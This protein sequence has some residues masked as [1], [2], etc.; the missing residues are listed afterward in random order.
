MG[1]LP[2]IIGQVIALEVPQARLA[3]HREVAQALPLDGLRP[4]FRVGAEVRGRRAPPLH[5]YHLERLVELRDEFHLVIPQ[6]IWSLSA[7]S[8]KCMA[9]LRACWAIQDR[10]GWA[11]TPAMWTRRLPTLMKNS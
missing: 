9:T 11:V 6:R 10:S 7:F 8:A 1:P 3:E 2:V 5:L 4:P